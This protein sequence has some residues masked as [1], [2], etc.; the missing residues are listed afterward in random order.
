[1]NGHSA[2]PIALEDESVTFLKFHIFTGLSS[3]AKIQG[4]LVVGSIDLSSSELNGN[5]RF[6]QIPTS[7]EEKFEEPEPYTHFGRPVDIVY[8]QK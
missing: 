6:Y 7:W 8:T 3:D 1:M 5:V 4:Q 2:T